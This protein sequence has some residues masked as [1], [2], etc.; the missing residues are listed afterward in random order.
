MSRSGYTVILCG[1]F[2]PIPALGLIKVTLLLQ[3]Y[4]LFNPMKWMRICVM[5]GLVVTSLFYTAITVTYIA[6]MAQRPGESWAV[7]LLSQHWV[8]AYNFFLPPGIV[9]TLLDW[10]LLILPIPAVFS[11]NMT[12]AKKIGV[13]SIFMTGGLAATAS[14]VSLYYRSQM[15]AI[16]PD[17]GWEVIPITIWV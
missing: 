9:G 16:L 10:Y 13:L 12:L 14:I 15:Y 11:L 3:Y 1:T 6:L 4:Q 2:L 5:S 8:E 17:A 7:T